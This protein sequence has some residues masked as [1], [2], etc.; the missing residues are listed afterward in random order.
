MTITLTVK[1]TQEYAAKCRQWGKERAVVFA[2]AVDGEMLKVHPQQAIAEGDRVA[3]QWEA[4]N[5]F[6]KL[7][8]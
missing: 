6:P 7:I 3:D 4:E 2:R 1:E 8:E 5:P